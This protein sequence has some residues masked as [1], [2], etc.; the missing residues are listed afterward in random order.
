MKRETD[1]ERQT[2]VKLTSEKTRAAVKRCGSGRDCIG[3]R[4]KDQGG[5]RRK[6]MKVT[7][8]QEKVE[9]NTTKYSCSAVLINQRTTLGLFSPYLKFDLKAAIINIFTLT[10]A[11]V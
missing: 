4:K 7:V 5:K 2:G 8:K 3:E 10:M 9:R 1:R 11:H 6:E